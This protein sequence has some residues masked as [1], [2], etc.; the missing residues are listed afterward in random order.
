[1]QSPVYLVAQTLSY[2]GVAIAAA[3]ITSMVL[4]TQY[5]LS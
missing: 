4:A 5:I 2:V 1:M 3:G